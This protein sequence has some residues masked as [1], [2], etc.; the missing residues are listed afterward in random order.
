MDVVRL[1]IMDGHPDVN[2]SRFYKKYK[3][4]LKKKGLSLEIAYTNPDIFKINRYENIFFKWIC[5]K[6]AVLI[7]ESSGD[8]F[9]YSLND[10]HNKENNVGIHIQQ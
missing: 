6:V 3:I 2:A 10:G 1:R 7:I 5:L 8:S 9:R 4:S